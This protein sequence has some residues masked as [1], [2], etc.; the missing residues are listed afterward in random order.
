MTTI[1]YP[2]DAATVV[3]SLRAHAEKIRAARLEKLGPLSDHERRKLEFVTA[4]ILDRFL[5]LPATRLT[6]AGSAVERA[7]YADAVQR[8]FGLGEDA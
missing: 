5:A 4:R 3:A 2:P 8:L 7:T 1:T 6:Q